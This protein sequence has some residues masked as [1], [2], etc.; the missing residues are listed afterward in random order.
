V[1][2]GDGDRPRCGTQK[3]LIEAAYTQDILPVYTEDEAGLYQTVPYPGS[4]KLK[5]GKSRLLAD[6]E[7]E[8]GDGTRSHAPERF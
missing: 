2:D 3:N 8:D 4:R 7:P 1:R 5:P 6:A